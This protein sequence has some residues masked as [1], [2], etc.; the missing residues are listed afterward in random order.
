MKA[1]YNTHNREGESDRSPPSMSDAI[2]ADG[3]Q[4]CGEAE[5]LVYVAIIPTDEENAQIESDKILQLCEEHYQAIAESDEFRA[6]ELPEPVKADGKRNRRFVIE[7]KVVVLEPE[8]EKAW[9]EF[10][11]KSERYLSGET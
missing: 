7:G 11:K 5:D 1:E 3:C 6:R 2:Q 4:F 8:N 10:K 9:I